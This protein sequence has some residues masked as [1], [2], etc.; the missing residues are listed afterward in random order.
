MSHWKK[1]K[2]KNTNKNTCNLNSLVSKIIT[3]P[4]HWNPQIHTRVC[5]CVLLCTTERYRSVVYTYDF[6]HSLLQIVYSTFL[7]NAAFSLLIWLSHTHFFLLWKSWLNLR[8]CVFICRNMPL[9]HFIQVNPPRSTV[10]NTLDSHDEL[11]KTVMLHSSSNEIEVIQMMP[12]WN[13]N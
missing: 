4:L 2:D 8:T 5:V 10:L 13:H 9:N 3:S 11:L 12:I 6:V 1:E 7:S